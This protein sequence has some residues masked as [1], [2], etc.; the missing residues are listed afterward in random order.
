MLI[1]NKIPSRHAEDVL[2]EIRTRK[3][4]VRSRIKETA[5]YIRTTTH[6]LFTP[7][8]R[9]TSKLGSFMSMVDQGLAIYDGVMMGMRVARN[10]RR[11]FGRRR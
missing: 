10:I 7:P 11:I 9:A 8:P 1:E 5:G 6:D 4:E 2:Q 3:A